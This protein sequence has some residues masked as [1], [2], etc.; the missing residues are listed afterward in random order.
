MDYSL[1][2]LPRSEIELQVT[3]PFSEFEAHVRR[4]AVLISEDIEIEG[5]RKGK[6]PYDVVKS[7]VGE[8]AVYE[9]A[10]DLAV[11]KT[12]PDVL[13][14]LGEQGD[15]SPEQPVIGRPEITVTKLAPGNPLEYK[16]RVA[17]LP[18]VTLPDYRSIATRTLQDKKPQT[19][20]DEEIAGALE[21]LRESRVSLVA[22]DRPAARGDRVEV[23]FDIRSDGVKIADGESRNHPF[24]LGHGRFIPGFE[25]ALEGM[26]VNQ[27]KEFSLT[28]PADWRDP[29][30]AGKVLDIRAAMKT[31]QE[32][33]LPEITDDFAKTL[34]N[35]ASVETMR[36][37]IREGIAA[38]KE[39]KETQRVRGA[40]IQAI[41]TDAT[42]EIPQT[43]IDAEMEKMADELRR[44]VAE[45]GMSWPD[46]LLHIKKSEEE[47]KKEWQKEGEHRVR[48]A[49]VLR[50]IGLKEKIE[51]AEEELAAREQQILGGLRTASQAQRTI[52]P[53]QLR[54]YTHS[55]LRNE[56]VFEFLERIK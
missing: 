27:E 32:R 24:T 42:M 20:T 54:E 23:D 49:L 4:A 46:Y 2:K 31:V 43:L 50:E 51:P 34:G 35:F 11:R 56:K 12:Y 22:V 17:V 52:D 10:A 21:W 53:V 19:V 9:R 1:T 13:A 41:A 28:V 25:D 55:V 29:A 14:S 16:V 47:L 44:G 15:L 45:I 6:A 37:S 33:K 8:A 26:S 39:E 38:E 5:F 3:L 36:Q 40:M 18:T 30:F 7:R 48:V